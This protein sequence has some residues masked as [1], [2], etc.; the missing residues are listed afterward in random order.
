MVVFTCMDLCEWVYVLH[1]FVA[2]VMCF[3]AQKKTLELQF[4]ILLEGGLGKGGLCK[5]QDREGVQMQTLTF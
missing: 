2:V 4:G 3:A 5:C 1:N